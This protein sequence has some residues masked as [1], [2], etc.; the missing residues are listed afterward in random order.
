MGKQAIKGFRKVHIKTAQ[1]KS[2]RK[3]IRNEIGPLHS[4]LLQPKTY[5]RYVAAYT[6]LT[7]WLSFVALA[8][9]L[10]VLPCGLVALSRCFVSLACRFVALA[11]LLPVLPCGLAALSLCFASLTCRVL[12]LLLCFLFCL[13]ALWLC[14][15]AVLLWL[16]AFCA[17]CS[18]SCFALRPCG[19]V[20]LLCFFGLSLFAF[21]ALLPW[22]DLWPCGFLSVCD[23]VACCLCLGSYGLSRACG[24]ALSN[25]VSGRG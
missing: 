5:R 2:Q 16:V 15:F 21:A 13:V 9:L 1:D 25:R 12:R 24:S 10:P 7:Q 23:L 19:F 17:C 11:A 8:A 18:A 14:R 4:T 3:D 20:A 6:A 22:F